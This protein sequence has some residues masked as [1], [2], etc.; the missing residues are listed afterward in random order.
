MDIEGTLFNLHDTVGL[1]EA[2]GGT[3]AQLAKYNAI[4]QFYSL[5]RKLETG[6]LPISCMRGPENQ[7]VGCQELATCPRNHTRPHDSS[8]YR[9]GER[10]E[11]DG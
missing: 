5:H 9:A 6:G 7:Q 1:E 4:L 8:R 11:W 10:K 3:V 2:Q